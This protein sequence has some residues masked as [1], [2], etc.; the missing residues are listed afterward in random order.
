MK[1]SIIHPYVYKV[2]E[3]TLVI[4]PCEKLEERDKKLSTFVNTAL[5][6]GV[7]VLVQMYCHY[8]PMRQGMVN[9]AFDLDPEYAWMFDEQVDMCTTNPYGIPIPNDRPLSVEPEIW[10]QLQEICISH[11]DLG[12]KYGRE[13]VLFVGGMVESC[14]VNAILY[15]NKRYRNGTQGAY[16]PEF[17]VSHDEHERLWTFRRFA[18]E[19][20]QCK[21]YDQAMDLIVR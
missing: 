4:G 2:L 5:D 12:Q 6:E 11:D 8:G 7:D 14:L 21:T 10:E 3:D 9:C 18:K 16:V 1:V 20:V 17:C 15:W 19:G 13:D